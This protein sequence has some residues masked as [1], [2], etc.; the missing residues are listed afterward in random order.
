MSIPERTSGAV[1]SEQAVHGLFLP[2]ALVLLA[3]LLAGCAGKSFEDIRPGI[4]TR[5][6]YIENVPFVRQADR[7]C[8]PAALAGVFAFWGRPIDLERISS[9][10]YLPKLSGALPMDLERFSKGSGFQTFTPPGS[11]DE[12]RSYLRRNQP[13]ICLLDQGFGLYRQPHYVTVIGFDD[14]NELI[15][16][17]DGERAS[18]TMSYEKFEKF[19]ARAGHWML[20]MTPRGL[21]RPQ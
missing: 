11:F 15:I 14:G 19:W 2:F 4:E 3:A 8:G 12:L 17:H 9:Q 21:E 13:V 10:V 7:D 5:G 20:A 18:R 16:M 6:H 1:N